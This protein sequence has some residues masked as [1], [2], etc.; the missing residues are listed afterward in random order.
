MDAFAAPDPEMD[1]VADG[2][3]R[4]DP[5]GARWAAVVRHTY[6]MIYNGAETGRYRWDQ[7]MKTEKTHFG[8]LFEINAQREFEFEGGDQTDYRIAGHQVDA[9]WS[10]KEGS[11]MLPPEVFG[12][13]ALVATGNDERAIWSLGLVR[14]RQEYRLEGANRD[15]KTT[16]NALGRSSVRWLWKD[17]AMPA[18]ILLQLPRPAV[19]DLFTRKHGTQRTNQLFRLAE[20]QLVHRSAVR[21]VAMQL[22]DQKRVRA[23]GGARSAL[24]PEGYI[25]ISGTWEKQ[26]QIAAD[27]GVPVPSRKE[28]ISVRIVP[29]ESST[30]VEIKG[31]HWRRAA[32]GEDS[33]TPAPLFGKAEE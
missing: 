1:A 25:I 31:E 15:K 3:L 9:K 10:Q 5:D 16:L 27:L 18:N 4:N 12:R 6:D 33:T 21:T 22:D 13:L 2:L 28:Y 17:A 7:L 29:A 19:D 14:V 26:K 30:G 8:T 23:N 32:P 11:W 24:A 20:G